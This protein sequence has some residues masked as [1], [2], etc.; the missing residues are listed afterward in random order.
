MD[1]TEQRAK[2]NQNYQYSEALSSYENK[3]IYSKI[4]GA[5]TT[6]DKYKVLVIG[7]SVSE[8]SGYVDILGEKLEGNFPNKTMIINTGMGGYNTEMEYKY[9]TAKGI[10]AKPNFVVIQLHSN[11]IGGT[12]VVIKKDDQW[13]AYDNSQITAEI[14]PWFYKNSYLYR[15]LIDIKILF[16]KKINILN[17]ASSEV[18]QQ[19]VAEYLQKIIQALDSQNIPFIIVSFPI[20]ENTDY[21]NQL[22][23]Q[24]SVIVNQLRSNHVYINMDSVYAQHS[25]EDITLDPDHPNEYGASVAAEAIYQALDTKLL[26]EQSPILFGDDNIA[27]ESAQIET[28]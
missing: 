21:A 25:L 5:S 14:N 26:E 4:L 28:K 1:D 2:A 13:I 17:E 16:Y 12:P 8:W 18:L 7:D 20:L 15:Q 10:Q 6:N 23:S 11:D 27:S 22:N 3:E 19:N 9:F 24:I